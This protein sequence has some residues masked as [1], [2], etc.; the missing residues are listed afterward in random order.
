MEESKTEVLVFSGDSQ[1]R[2]FIEILKR[3]SC[4]RCA[5][6][7]LGFNQVYLYRLTC[8]KNLLLPLI[9]HFE[10]LVYDDSGHIFKLESDKVSS[11]C[12]LCMGILQYCDKV[13]LADKL[14][15]A[16]KNTPYQRVDYKLKV[17]M[18]RLQTLNQYHVLYEISLAC[19]ALFNY[20]HRLDK[21]VIPSKD[22]FKWIMA[23]F[24]NKGAEL[25]VNLEGEFFLCVTFEYPP[26]IPLVCFYL[27]NQCREFLA[28][29]TTKGKKERQDHKPTEEEQLPN[30]KLVDKIKKLQANEYVRMKM[31][32]KLPLINLLDNPEYLKLKCKHENTYLY[33]SYTKESR[34]I[35][36]VR[37]MLG[38]KRKV[39]NLHL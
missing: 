14:I 28:K 29:A 39:I 12:Q 16:L 23:P 37:W 33:G 24:I 17:K 35:S 22:I 7:I 27:Y 18:P 19:P 20:M 15:K 4:V 2:S 1:K 5:L 32:E 10:S 11:I 21:Q 9:E 3:R 38:E 34:D 8:Y 31:N 13:A 30:K 36:Q 26:E 6:R 25:S